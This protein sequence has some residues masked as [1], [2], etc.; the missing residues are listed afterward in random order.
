MNVDPTVEPLAQQLGQNNTAEE[1]NETKG[2]A[3]KPSG[4]VGFHARDIRWIRV[5]AEFAGT[6]LICLALYL[7]FTFSQILLDVPTVTLP[8][9]G[10]AV[11]YIVVT[12]MLGSISGG[13]FNPAVT[14]AAMFTSQISVIDGILYIVS[15]LVGAVCAAAVLIGFVPSNETFPAKTWLMFTVNGFGSGSPTAATLAQHHISFGTGLAIIVELVGGL[16]VVGTAVATLRK[17]GRPHKNHALYTG[18][19]YGAGTLIT[20]PITNAGLNPAR[21]TGIA[22]FAQSKDM[23]VS[24]LSQLWLFWICPLLAASLV[25]LIVILSGI[26]TDGLRNRA[27]IA[28]VSVGENEEMD[29]S[30]ES[31]DKGNDDTSVASDPK[32][33]AE[34]EKDVSEVTAAGATVHLHS[35][36]VDSYLNR[37]KEDQQAKASSDSED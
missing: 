18:L 13:H 1:T 14:V 34:E 3:N 12:A 25:A 23:A 4:K 11:I 10:T 28:K 5:G 9:I 2:T 35:S 31:Q 29:P 19:A 27:R 37:L 22:I 24:P 26:V 30:D 21:S 33:V 20:Y 17:D 7:T 8:V 36:E 6:L 32:S 15:Q 16:L